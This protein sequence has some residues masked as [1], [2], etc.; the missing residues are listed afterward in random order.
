MTGLLLQLKYNC[1]ST[2]FDKGPPIFF[3]LLLC[4]GEMVQ[5]VFFM[6]SHWLFASKYDRL[7]DE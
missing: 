1:R 4:L 3:I 7:A 6:L 2:G 5:D